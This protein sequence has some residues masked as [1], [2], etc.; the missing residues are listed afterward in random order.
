MFF[1]CSR[2]FTFCVVRTLIVPLL[3]TKLVSR[4]EYYNSYIVDQ[5]TMAKSI[6]SKWR[7]KMRAIKRIRYGVK[8]LD[9]LKNMLVNAG[10]IEVKEGGEI[11]HVCLGNSFS[12]IISLWLIVYL[13]CTKYTVVKGDWAFG[14][15]HYSNI[16][17]V[18]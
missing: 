4:Y 10:E 3:S 11:E 18:Q 7:R 8:E 17:A 5:F 14:S 1:F 6:R 16:Y 13:L 2:A 12:F 15:R 9:R